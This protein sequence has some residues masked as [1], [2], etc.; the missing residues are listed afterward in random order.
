M[1]TPR[2]FSSLK[3]QWKNQ[4]RRGSLA[5]ALVTPHERAICGYEESDADLHGRPM[6]TAVVPWPDRRKIE[7]FRDP[8]GAVEFARL[9]VQ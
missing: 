6:S 9:A 1:S 4:L 8:R 5:A 7:V 3:N 2:V